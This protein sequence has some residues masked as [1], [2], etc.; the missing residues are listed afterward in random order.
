MEALNTSQ[1]PQWKQD[2]IM[3][4]GLTRKV[5][6]LTSQLE[7]QSVA[8]KK[9]TQAVRDENDYLNHCAGEIL[10][11]LGTLPDTIAGQIR[12]TTGK[13]TAQLEEKTAAMVEST[14]HCSA[15]ADAMKTH[16]PTINASV[17]KSLDGSHAAFSA[18]M[19]SDRQASEACHEAARENLNG[20]KQAESKFDS[21][22]SIGTKGLMTLASAMHEGVVATCDEENNFAAW[23]R[24]QFD[25]QTGQQK[26][27]SALTLATGQGV[28]RTELAMEAGINSSTQSQTLLRAGIRDTA[29][30]LGNEMGSVDQ[31]AGAYVQETIQR[32]TGEPM[33][34]NQCSYPTAFAKNPPYETTLAH[35]AAAW[36]HETSVTSGGKVAGKGTD[37]PGSIGAEDWSGALEDTKDVLLDDADAEALALAERMSD[38]EEYEGLYEGEMGGE[39]PPASPGA[40]KRALP[41]RPSTGSLSEMHVTTISE[42]KKREPK[43]ATVKTATKS[44]RRGVNAS[45]R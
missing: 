22:I 39:A 45:R 3:I 30:S 17:G 9:D 44:K 7:K 15:T 36:S 27:I 26:H 11:R 31:Q 33:T 42:Q 41:R 1:L 21:S 29:S 37:F 13:V 34:R 16:P 35:K 24:E 25:D 40:R 28:Q 8:H 23:T 18:N 4:D 5:E 10:G 20:L 6:Q 14:H 43:T 2:Q 19:A 32:D 38:T 12:S